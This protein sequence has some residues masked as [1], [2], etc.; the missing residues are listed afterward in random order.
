MLLDFFQPATRRRIRAVDGKSPIVTLAS[1]IKLT[2]S[3]KSFGQR[4]LL[5]HLLYVLNMG[6]GGGLIVFF[7]VLNLLFQPQGGREF[8]QPI[9]T[10]HGIECAVGI[11]VPGLRGQLFCARGRCLSKGQQCLCPQSGG[12]G[13]LREQPHHLVV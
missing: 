11:L 12:R 3:D 9:L 7:W 4:Q 1:L 8:R 5:R 2:Q 13:R 6:R 10:E